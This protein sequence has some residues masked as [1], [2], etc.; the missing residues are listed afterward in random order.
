MSNERKPHRHAALIK[1]WADGRVIQFKETNGDWTDS[2][3]PFWDETAEYRVK[4]EPVKVRY[5]NYVRNE[6]GGLFMVASLMDSRPFA[7][8]DQVEKL[9]CFVTWIHAEWQEVEVP[10]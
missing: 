9:P 4:P 2:P 1:Q 3:N 6:G 10:Q 5:R 7:S 8:P